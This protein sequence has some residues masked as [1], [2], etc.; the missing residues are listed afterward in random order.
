MG[1]C[2]CTKKYD[3]DKFMEVLQ[4]VAGPQYAAYAKHNFDTKYENVDP[5]EDYKE[6]QKPTI[7]YL[8]QAKAAAQAVLVNKNATAADKQEAQNAIN[9]VDKGL[10]HIT[11]LSNDPS[12]RS[13]LLDDLFNME[14]KQGF[15]DAASTANAISTG[16][17]EMTD[18]TKLARELNNKLAEINAQGLKEVSVYKQKKE[19]DDAN[20]AIALSGLDPLSKG[21]YM[22]A[23]TIGLKIINE[24]GTLVSIQSI[25]DN[26]LY[27]PQKTFLI[28]TSPV[29]ARDAIQALKIG[30]KKIAAFFISNNSDL[31]DGVKPKGTI[32]DLESEIVF[33]GDKYR[34]INQNDGER[35]LTPEEILV[36]GK[37]KDYDVDPEVIEPIIGRKERGSNK[38]IKF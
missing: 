27:A 25:Q 11:S 19:Y 38:K 14:Y 21:I 35:A 6:A 34:W 9:A 31:W 30:N 17:M 1:N 23:K 24:D 8:T 32:E 12:L 15:S 13:V 18:A 20:S 37:L 28:G 22:R 3:E 2:C 16:K 36:K 7:A 10:A 4:Q 26:P 29:K 5:T 33:D